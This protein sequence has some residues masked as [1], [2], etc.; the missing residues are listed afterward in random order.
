[1]IQNKNFSS[2]L[3]LLDVRWLHADD[4]VHDIQRLGL[5]GPFDRFRDRLLRLRVDHSPC[6]PQ[7]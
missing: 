5:C 3:I 7:Y 2:Y 1:M 4:G 6:I